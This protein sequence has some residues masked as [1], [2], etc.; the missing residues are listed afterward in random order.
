MNAMY[1]DVIL[2]LPIPNFYTY[3]VPDLYENTITIGARVVVQFGPKKILTA[4]VANLHDVKPPIYDPKPILSLIDESP[5]VLPVQLAFFYWMAD[6]YMCHK[7]EVINAALPSG[8]KLSSESKIQIHPLF[9]L[10]DAQNSTTF[11]VKELDLLN[12]INTRE[13]ITYAEASAILEVKN[14]Y[15]YLNSLQKKQAIV[16]FEEV[17]E[18]FKPKIVKKIRIAEKYAADKLSLEYLIETLEKKPKQL[19]VLLKYLQKVPIYQSK[20]LNENGILKAE[21]LTNDISDSVLKTMVKNEIFEAFDIVI[22]RLEEMPQP[23]ESTFTLSAAQ[24]KAKDEI[25]FHFESK[26]TVLLHGITGSGKTEVYIELIKNVLENGQ[27]VLFLLPEIALT[28]QIVARMYKVFGSILGVYHSKYSDNERVEVW[29]GLLTHKFQIIVGVRSSVF[30]PFNNLGLVIIDEEHE[31][32]YK[33]YEPAPRYN[34]RDSA[35]VLAQKH[36]AKVLLGS[37]TPSVET[38]HN[39]KVHKWELVTLNQRFGEAQ[40]PDIELVDLKREKQFKTM[41]LEFSAPL[42]DAIHSQMKAKKQSILFQNRR[43]YSPYIS[44]EDCGFVP[45]CNSCDVSLTFHLHKKELSCHYCGYH[46][47]VPL[48]CPACGSSKIKAVGFGTEKLEEEAQLLFADA[49]IQR[50]DLDTT[51]SKTGFQKI[52]NAVEN[53]EIDILVG[54]QMVTKGLDFENVSL[55]G[56]FDIDRM[57][58]F[59]DFRSQERVFQLLTQ[60]SG[61]A[62]RKGNKGKVIIQTTQPNTAVFQY[63]IQHNYLDFYEKEIVERQKYAYPPFTRLIKI[64]LKNKDKLLVERASVV[65]ADL[66]KNKL[67]KTRILGPESPPIDRI[68]DLFLKEMYIKLEKE[69][70]DMKKAKELVTAQIQYFLALPDFKQMLCVVDVDPV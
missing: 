63:V 12:E 19:D 57:I 41:Q 24:Q 55:V 61:R 58:H 2:P 18:K 40:L 27:Q 33:Q 60:V 53:E 15:N 1:C 11:S 49:R 37:A 38:F 45:Q 34:A 7:G 39:C 30:L 28:T 16:I 25:L 5:I 66:L 32:S 70:V 14:I 17:R 4:I 13:S 56:V 23:A 59:P 48:A 50:M 52:I 46:E 62:G 35:L 69:T 65:L 51:R 10:D 36:H 3:L 29:Q 22:S 6:Y 64:S 67:G 26:Q 43:G 31:P 68:R 54:T 44:C 47:R 42:F 20:G 9:K 8:L 21:L